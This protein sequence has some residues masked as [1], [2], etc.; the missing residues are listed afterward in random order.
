MRLIDCPACGHQLSKQAPIC[1]ECG[2]PIKRQPTRTVGRRRLWFWLTFCLLIGGC[3]FSQLLPACNKIED[4]KKRMQRGHDLKQV[5]L[6]A[7]SFRGDHHKMPANADDLQ[8]Y[9]KEY[10]D[11]MKGLK[12]GE[13][14]VVWNARTPEDQIQ[15]SNTLL[16]A[17]ETTAIEDG[18]L[19]VAFIDG[20]VRSV[21]EAEFQSTPKAIQAE[22][23]ARK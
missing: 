13:I 20:S 15:K 3:F 21:S 11:S 19:I 1:S 17:W 4:A 23:P 22:P 8:P 5:V 14:E 12:S 9:L 18:M 10:P 16:Y 7:Y 2:H 6:A